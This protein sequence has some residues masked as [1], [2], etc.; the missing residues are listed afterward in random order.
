MQLSKN[1]YFTYKGYPPLFIPK[2]AQFIPSKNFFPIF[3]CKS[4][5]FFEV[6]YFDID[7][8]WIFAVG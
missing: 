8:R 3:F 4:V 6:N 7:F 1:Q 5:L 2:S